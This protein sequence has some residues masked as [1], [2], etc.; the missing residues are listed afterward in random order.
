MRMR[1][2][3]GPRVMVAAVLTLLGIGLVAMPAAAQE[4]TLGKASYSRHAVG[5]VSSQASCS[6]PPG[7]G[8]VYNHAYVGT[9]ACHKCTIAGDLGVHGG[10]WRSYRCWT[11]VSGPGEWRTVE[12][13]VRGY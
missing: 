2:L 11:T 5:P 1:S 10:A 13:W 12:L 4:S 7:D 8:Y 6:T 3:I 9:N